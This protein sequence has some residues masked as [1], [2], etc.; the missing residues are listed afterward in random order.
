ME[1]ISA[2]ADGEL[3]EAD[4]KQV[5][6]HLSVCEN[7]SAILD[8][9]GEA[10][11]AVTESCLPAP[12]ALL[13]GVMNEIL[14]GG[15]ADNSDAAE[16]GAGGVNRIA[17]TAGA[18]ETGTVTN[19]AVKR[20]MPRLILTR[21]VPIAACLALV[22]LTVPRF[23]DFSRSKSDNTSGKS[24]SMMESAQL[25]PQFSV[26]T[27]GASEGPA[28]EAGTGDVSEFAGGSDSGAAGQP[29]PSPS[30]AASSS[31][32][33]LAPGMASDN[34]DSDHDEIAPAPEAMDESAGADGNEFESEVDAA[35]DSEEAVN[36][37]NEPEEA[38]M[39]DEAM[40]E[41]QEA[42]DDASRFDEFPVITGVPPIAGIPDLPPEFPAEGVNINDLIA[43]YEK[44][45]SILFTSS[46]YAII[47]V[48]GGLPAITA[49]YGLGYMEDREMYFEIPREAAD[50]IIGFA[51]DLEGVSVTIVDEDGEFAVLMYKPAS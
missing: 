37:G 18:A 45:A 24:M 5:E 31:A 2:Y 19:S 33:A 17:G 22:L 14:G 49:M 13:H 28:G 9:Y 42:V 1:L 16:A 23:I 10:S 51:R 3:T 4:K 39:Q 21:Y 35:P 43:E 25:A 36:F 7:C 30:S 26:Q 34:S 6:E 32:E 20:S 8:I 47:E 46:I 41:P 50:M 44:G 29:A 48:N 12:E 11:N 15:A 27:G 40:A 38:S